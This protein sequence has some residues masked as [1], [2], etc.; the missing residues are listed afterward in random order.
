MTRATLQPR[1]PLCCCC[2]HYGFVH[3][4]ESGNTRDGPATLRSLPTGARDLIVNASHP[5]SPSQH[6]SAYLIVG[7]GGIIGHAAIP[8]TQKRWPWQQQRSCQPVRLILLVSII[9]GRDEVALFGHSRRREF[10]TEHNVSQFVHQDAVCSGRALG[11][12]VH[13]KII[14]SDTDCESG[15]AFW[16]DHDQMMYVVHGHTAHVTLS[17]NRHSQMVSKSTCRQWTL[18]GEAQCLS[19]FDGPAFTL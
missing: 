19:E 9:V 18:V 14:A 2:L 6:I 1:Q 8:D 13:H 16:I 5:D 4:P 15:P 10:M 11:R 12:V 17:P 7:H 3:H